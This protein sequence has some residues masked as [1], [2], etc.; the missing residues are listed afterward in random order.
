MDL[1]EDVTT[2][3]LI[4]AYD[5]TSITVNDATYYTPIMLD[6]NRI[7]ELPHLLLTEISPQML[8]DFVPSKE[9][10]SIEC[11]LIG[12]GERQTHHPIELIAAFH[13]QGLGCEIMT[14]PAACRTFNIMSADKRIIVAILII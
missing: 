7:K 5:S 1:N 2:G 4:R 12:C 9:L 6:N 10:Q 14:T 11:V 8:A 13:Q 3:N